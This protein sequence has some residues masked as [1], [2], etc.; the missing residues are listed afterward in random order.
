M[1]KNKSQGKSPFVMIDDVLTDLG[2]NKDEQPTI[3]PQQKFIIMEEPSHKGIDLDIQL[4]N[5]VK[6]E[7]SSG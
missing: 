7:V 6:E 4:E 5:Q 2:Q 1:T 3:P